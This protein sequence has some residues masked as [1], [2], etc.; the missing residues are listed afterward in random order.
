MY[1]INDSVCCLPCLLFCKNNKNKLAKLPGF[2]KWHKVGD[3]YNSHVNSTRSTISVKSTSRVQHN[4]EILKSVTKIIEL[5]GK[6]Y[7]AFRGQRENVANNE[8]NCGNFLAILKL[9]AQ[10]NDKNKQATEENF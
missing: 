8:N 3:K 10:T 1:K 2:S 6:Q 9:L 4:R 7:I 5:C